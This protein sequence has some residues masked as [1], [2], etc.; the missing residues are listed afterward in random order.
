[1]FVR[2]CPLAFFIPS[3][4]LQRVAVGVCSKAVLVRTRAKAACKRMS[5]GMFKGK[6]LSPEDKLEINETSGF[7]LLTGTLLA[8][9]LRGFLMNTFTHF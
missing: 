7:N 1:M 5:N 2:L 3:A 9:L 6:R 8:F 4:L